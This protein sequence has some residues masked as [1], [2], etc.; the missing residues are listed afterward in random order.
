M[1]LICLTD[2]LLGFDYVLVK[3][4]GGAL[5]GV[6]ESKWIESLCFLFSVFF[7]FFRFFVRQNPSSRDFLGIDVS[8]SQSL[9]HL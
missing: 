7:W 3:G 1:R 5:V 9:R 8:L 4:L 6:F 2:L